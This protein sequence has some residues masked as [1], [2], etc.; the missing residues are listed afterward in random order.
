MLISME[1]LNYNIIT[2]I[3]IEIRADW[4]NRKVNYD[5]LL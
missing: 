3:I 1:C 2:A 4:I 5:G